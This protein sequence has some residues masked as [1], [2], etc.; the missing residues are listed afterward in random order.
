MIIF[1]TLLYIG[2]LFLLVRFKIVP[3]NTFWKISPAIWMVLLFV[4]L[5]IPMNWGAPSGPIVVIKQSVAI[6]PNVAGEVVDV[7]VQPN[8]QL[9]AGDVLFRIDPTPYEAK[10]HQIEA[11]L[12]LAQ[13]NLGR[14]SQLEQRQVGTLATLQQR[15]AEVDSLS[16]RLSA[17][18][19]DLDKTVVR[20]PSDGFVTNVGLRKGARVAAFP[21][22]AVMAFIETADTIVGVQVQQ[23]Y[24][25][26]IAPGQPVEL[27]FKF[28]PGKVY[29]GRVVA[30]LP[31]TELGQT[32]A[33]GTAV[34]AVNVQATPFAVRVAL[35]DPAVA[36]QLPAGTTG[37]AA[38]YTTSAKPTHIIRR[39]MIRMTA[40]LNYVNPL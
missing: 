17:A 11:Q 10:V 38:I 37:T 33:S 22:A 15:E 13:I 6:V 7:P 21:V 32:Q 9:K 40:W 2:I 26:H 28:L 24:A 1:L 34:G 30:L 31:A 20:A 19:W 36:R 18:K 5:F 16:A 4:I 23:I 27:A 25:R 35:D 12:K 3:W 29:T 14:A 8:K 39:V